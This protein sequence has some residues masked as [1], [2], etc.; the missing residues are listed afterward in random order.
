M[1]DELW[2]FK[3]E[4]KTLNDY[5][6]SEELQVKLKKIISDVPN[7]ILSG[8]PGVGKSTFLNILLNE[9]G[10]DY[11][12]INA[13]VEN[14]AE[15]IRN[16]VMNFA[17]SL[18]MTKYKIIYL[19]E[20][21]RLTEAAQEMLRQLM[22]DVQEHTRFAFV[23]N[24][25]TEIHDAIKSR[26]ILEE[27]KSPPADKIY[28]FCKSILSKEKIQYDSFVNTSILKMI[29]TL[30]PDI[31]RIINSIQGSVINKEIKSLK[32]LSKQSVYDK[33]CKSF[34]EKDINDVRELLRNNNI[35]YSDLYAMLYDNIDKF[36][37]PGD[38]IILLSKY[39]YQDKFVAINELNFMAM[40]MEMIKNGII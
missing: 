11:L 33:I 16:K 15:I 22:E 28:E 9:T 17:T 36:N 37:S 19:N 38:A 29:K 39:V 8:P 24:S 18:G 27:L 23:C 10:Y 26:C 32:I 6:A 5:I 35:I 31:R 2:T 13:S 12:K 30:Y 14:G 3:Y 7:F 20:A 21:E 1:S 40:I 25:H 4:P 34:F